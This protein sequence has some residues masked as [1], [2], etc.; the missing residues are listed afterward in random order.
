MINVLFGL[1]EE[2]AK[3]CA[4][5]IISILR[6]HKLQSEQDKIHF[7]FLGN[8]KKE[9]KEKLIS[10][11]IIQSFEYTFL[12]VDTSEFNGLPKM[13]SNITVAGYNRLLA[14]ELLPKEVSKAIYLDC[15]IVLNADIEKIWKLDINNYLLAAVRD[16]HPS[17]PPYLYVGGKVINDTYFNS[18]FMFLNL[19]NLRDF[20]FYS[21]WKK[22]VRNHPNI[23]E[24]K[25]PDQDILNVVTQNKVL[26]LSEDFNC[27]NG[28]HFTN[29]TIVLHFG[30]HKPWEP[31][32]LHTLEFKKLYWK[33]ADVN[34]WKI[35]S[36]LAKTKAY[37]KY[38]V[39]FLRKQPLFFLK[40][41]YYRMILDVIYYRLRKH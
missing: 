26:L 15:D 6:N 35:N 16:R 33:Y 30:G 25:F 11:N 31:T 7:F 3:Y 32:C 22:Y 17:P 19:K 21:K 40:K 38:V 36:N 20:D 9:S 28:R 14:T 4:T 13:S 41:K 23:S 18:G 24:L 8:L 1:D 39:K 34:P 12:E 5:T 10:L 2:Y 27:S 37:I 29:K